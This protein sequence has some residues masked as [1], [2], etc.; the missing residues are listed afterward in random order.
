MRRAPQNPNN[1]KLFAK[2][3][4]MDLLALREHSEKELRTKVRESFRRSFRAR[5]KLR[6]EAGEEF[7]EELQQERID[8]AIDEAIEFAKLNGWMGNPENI[9]EKMA[10]AL[11]RRGKGIKYI[12]NY[13]KTRGLPEVHGDRDLE[14]EKALAL[15]K[16]KYSHFDLSSLPYEEK[17][18][19]QARVARYLASRGFDSEIVRKVI[20]EKL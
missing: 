19:E 1:P 10:G 11:H 7:S 13:L 14:L 20:Y 12:N 16:N 3:K 17:K 15:V 18:K 5:K 9:A 8:A 4:V 2:N 6:E